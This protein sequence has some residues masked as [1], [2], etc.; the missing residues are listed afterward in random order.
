M[1]FKNIKKWGQNYERH[2]YRYLRVEILDKVYT[3][4]LETA[5]FT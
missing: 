1:L 4:I 3:R 5:I 2:S